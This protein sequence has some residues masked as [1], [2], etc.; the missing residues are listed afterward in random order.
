MSQQNNIRVEWLP[1]RSSFKYINSVVDNFPPAEI[2]AQQER[3]VRHG[4]L[5]HPQLM[6]ESDQCM[7]DVGCGYGFYTLTALAMLA[8]HVY[9]FDK[10]KE[11][12]RI[13][14]ENI[15]LNNN[16]FVER[17]S[18]MNRTVSPIATNL[19]NFFYEELSYPPDRIKWIVVNVGG[20][21][22]RN[23]VN[24]ALKIIERN[25]PISLLVHHYDGYDGHIKFTNEFIMGNGFESKSVGIKIS[26]SKVISTSYIY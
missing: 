17:C 23:I 14:R 26:D 4:W 19:D 16:S 1:D 20:Q 25:R 10:N 15:R 11:M 3:E 18:V 6:I 13:L 9:A 2:A 22:E 24:G 21:D 12:V 8:R 5:L 7:I